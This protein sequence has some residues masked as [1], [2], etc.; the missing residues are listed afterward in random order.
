MQEKA[1][2]RLYGLHNGGRRS[3]D[4]AL[5]IL[6]RRWPVAVGTY[7]AFIEKLRGIW[8]KETDFC[9]APRNS[10]KRKIIP[11]GFELSHETRENNNQAANGLHFQTQNEIKNTLT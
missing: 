4:A 9:N 5:R 10:A 6:I 8:Q 2:A 3:F 7:P 1:I 11:S